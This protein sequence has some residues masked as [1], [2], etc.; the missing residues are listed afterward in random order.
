MGNLAPTSSLQSNNAHTSTT[1]TATTAN[2]NTSS[3]TL[4]PIGKPVISSKPSTNLSLPLA[5]NGLNSSLASQNNNQNTFVLPSISAQQQSL[6]QFSNLNLNSK[7]LS[8]NINNNNNNNNN[9]NETPITISYNSNVNSLFKGAAGTS[10]NVNGSSNGNQ[11]SLPL[12]KQNTRDYRSKLNEAKAFLDNENS[13]LRLNIEETPV[14]TRP[15]ILTP[16]SLSG[17]S[18]DN[19]SVGPPPR[20]RRDI[21]KPFDF[22]NGHNLEHA[23]NHQRPNQLN[24]NSKTAGPPQQQNNS[25][26]TP[27][28]LFFLNLPTSSSRSSSPSSSL[29]SSSSSQAAPNSSSSYN[30]S[31]LEAVNSD[32]FKEIMTNAG[33]LLINEKR[34]KTSMQDLSP[35]CELGSGTCGH[36]IKMKHSLSECEMA[37]KQ[38]RI[39]G[40]AEEN[41]RIIMDLDVVLK[42]HDC[43]DIVKCMGYFIS[44]GDVWICMEL[45]S[46]CFDK[47]AKLIKSPIP[48]DILGK[49]TVSTLTALNYLKE[50]HNVIHRDIKPSNILIDENGN[51]KLCDFGISGNLINSNVLSRNNAGCAG[52]MAPERIDPADP[53]N[54]IYDI[55]ADVWSLGITLVELATGEYP[56][57][58]CNTEFEVMSTILTCDAPQLVGAKFSDNFK[59]FVNQCLIKDVKKRPKYNILLKH[60]FV[61]HYKKTDVDV[62]AW[63]KQV[64]SSSLIISHPKNSSNAEFFLDESTNSDSLSSTPTVETISSSAIF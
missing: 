13:Q 58:H 37:V 24:V 15:S 8:S 22:K 19:N 56:Y 20:N 52:Y 32:K 57:K 54:P 14:A 45:M 48:E 11:F 4:A 1:T 64:T 62:K 17:L 16:I 30:C 39:S 23:A 49:M 29:S 28:P 7:T 6:R 38:M 35:V 41:K 34:I 33:S 21:L 25:D 60:P 44:E 51:I 50:Q 31:R 59:S 40:V 43:A 9:N 3:S 47:L 53:T 36:V 12:S 26:L 27:S 63:F 42:S 10:G 55:R 46:M 61:Q 2:A 18:I 5:T